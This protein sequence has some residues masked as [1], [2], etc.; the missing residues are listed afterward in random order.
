MKFIRAA[1]AYAARS[2]G[3]GED[4]GGFHW[5]NVFASELTGPILVK[6]PDFTDFLIRRMFECKGWELPE[7]LP[8]LPYEREAYAVTL[9]ELADQDADVPP[10]RT[11]GSLKRNRG[12]TFGN[13]KTLVKRTGFGMLG[14]S[15]GARPPVL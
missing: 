12:V 13:G 10:V 6:N 11:G 9:K 4:P 1:K 5:K 7:Q 2:C 8:V 3:G 14:A 15:R